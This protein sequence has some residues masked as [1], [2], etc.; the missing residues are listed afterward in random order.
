MIRKLILLALLDIGMCQGILNYNSVVLP[1]YFEP[2]QHVKENNYDE[3]G[4]T[5]TGELTVDSPEIERTESDDETD[6]GIIESEAVS[7]IS[8]LGQDYS[9]EPVPELVEPEPDCGVETGFNNIGDEGFDFEIDAQD[10]EWTAGLTYLGDWT[11]TA[12]CPCEICCG[13]YSSGYTASGT[14][15]TAGR[16]IACNELPFGTQVM[17]DGCIYTVEDTGWS[18]YGQ[19]I[20]IYFDSHDEALAYGMR[21]KEVYLVG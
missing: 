21:T 4:I 3:S 5:S 1:D 18:P 16:T 15:A 8:D 13:A 2:F 6:S 19:W 20:D 11:I 9:G 7:Y 12:Y 10:S 17:I 14:L